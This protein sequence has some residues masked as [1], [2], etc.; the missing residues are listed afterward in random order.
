MACAGM[1]WSGYVWVLAC[2]L[3]LGRMWVG[4]CWYAC[5]VL[6]MVIGWG[7]VSGWFFMMLDLVGFCPVGLGVG[8]NL[9]V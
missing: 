2:L 7:L 9:R 5:R 3:G 6:L 8:M 4:A 1:F